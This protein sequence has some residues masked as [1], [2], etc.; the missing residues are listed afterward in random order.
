ME[1]AIRWSTRNQQDATRRFLIADVAKNC[2][3]HGE[4]EEVRN[5]FVKHRTISRR[6]KLPNFTAFDWSRDNDSL[7]AIGTSVG[8]CRII[9]L[10][11]GHS[12]PEVLSLPV[13][14]QRKCN[15]LSFSRDDQL[16]VGLDRIR[17]DTSLNIYDLPSQNKEPVRRLTGAEVI[18][19]VKYFSDQ[20]QTLIA[21]SGGIARYGQSLK[22]YDLRGIAIA[23]ERML[24]F[25]I[26]TVCRASLSNSHHCP[27]TSC[28]CYFSGSTG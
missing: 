21:G 27:N 2:L 15:S 19:N 25:M 18:T 24:A 22:L 16:A 4:V 10:D 1:A 6:E 5:G 8:E 9:S 23:R 26:L 20:P 3:Q 17:G 14:F 7:V 28:P 13:K 12:N 11:P